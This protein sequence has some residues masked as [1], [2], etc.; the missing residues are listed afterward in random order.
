MVGIK[1]N[2]LLIYLRYPTDADKQMLAKQTG[3][4]RN[5][6]TQ[7]SLSFL[8]KLSEIML[9]CRLKANMGGENIL[10]L[11]SIKELINQR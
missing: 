10:K 2:S 5:Q 11:Y 9:S 8:S 3:L 1:P 6:V 4:S 7:I